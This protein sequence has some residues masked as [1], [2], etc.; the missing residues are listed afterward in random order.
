M[1]EKAS[2][3]KLRFE[4]GKGNL[5]VEDLWD[6]EL[7]ERKSGAVD[8]NTVAILV[9]RKLKETETESF[10]TDTPKA[11]ALLQLKMDIVKHIISVKL[12]EK[13]K[14]ATARVAKEKKDKILSII[15]KK[16]DEKL[17][18]TSLEE[19]QQIAASL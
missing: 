2:K 8:L 1:F 15:A 6:L 14:A 9:S 7:T 13:E 19:L 18:S 17:E 10:V 12:A 11:D 3:L 4:T 5:A 16:Q